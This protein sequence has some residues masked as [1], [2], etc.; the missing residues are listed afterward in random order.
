MI[1][2]RQHLLRLKAWM[3]GLRWIIL[4]FLFFATIGMISRVLALDDHSTAA[5][6]PFLQY[7]F[8]Y[9][10]LTLAG[11]FKSYLYLAF[12]YLLLLGIPR[13]IDYLLG[14]ESEILARGAEYPSNN[15]G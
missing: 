3:R 5:Y 8:W 14:V 15:G 1:H 10:S 2:D 11:G 6:D 9:K 12:T 4:L 13:G 7:N